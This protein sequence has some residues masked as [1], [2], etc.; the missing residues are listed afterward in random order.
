[1]RIGIFGGSF[2]PIHYGH[3][4]LAR[5]IMATGLVDEL[6]FLVSPHNPLKSEHTLM[7]DEQRLQRVSHAVNDI[8]GVKASD[9]EFGLPRPSYMYVTLSE[10]QKAYPCDTFTLIIGAD[11]WKCFS[12]WKNHKEILASYPI[13]IYPRRGYDID[14][15]KLPLTVTYIN[16]PLYDISSTQIREMQAQGEDVNTLL[17]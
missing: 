9:F 16:M 14:T 13:I 3:V 10:L 1:M 2:N 5:Q 11:N 8:K 15:T 4:G 6:W 7:P 12:H 17:P